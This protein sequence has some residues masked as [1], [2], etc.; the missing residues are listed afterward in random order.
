MEDVVYQQNCSVVRSG[1]DAR[2]RGCSPRLPCGLR[3]LGWSACGHY[4]QHRL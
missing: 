4:R 1:P 3:V 2:G